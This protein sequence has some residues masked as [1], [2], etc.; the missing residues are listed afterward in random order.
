MS[1]RLTLWRGEDLV[2]DLRKV[3][4][5]WGNSIKGVRGFFGVVS[6]EGEDF[7]FVFAPRFFF[8]FGF[9]RLGL[10]LRGGEEKV[11][12]ATSTIARSNG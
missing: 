7:C 11:N 8:F 4:G 6:R 1:D 3:L 5:L 9:F 2:K 12:K 10:D